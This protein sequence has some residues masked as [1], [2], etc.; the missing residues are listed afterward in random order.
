MLKIEPVRNEIPLTA[1]VGVRVDPLTSKEE[2]VVESS[3][4]Q[5][6]LSSVCCSLASYLSR[7]EPIMMER[8]AMQPNDSCCP[9]PRKK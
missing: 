4:S 8:M 1:S 6:T 3:D 2:G 5:L 7:M 9:V